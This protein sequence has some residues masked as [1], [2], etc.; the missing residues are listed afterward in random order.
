LE[1]NK[2]KILNA[3][4]FSESEFGEFISNLRLAESQRM[5]ILERILESGEI[6]LQDLENTFNISP[7][8]LNLN[9][10]YLKELDLLKPFAK[11][12]KLY[13]TIEKQNEVK[14]LFPDVSIIRDKHLCCGCGL[15]V[16]VCPVNAIDFLKD[17][18]TINSDS[19]I[20][21]G[22]C[23]ICCPRAF[24]PD[25]LKNL[26]DDSEFDVKFLNE[27]G[28]FE[29]IYTAQTK[30]NKIKEVG[31]DGGVVSTLLIT[32][33]KTQIID[34][35]LVVTS[36]NL[37]KPI[38]ILIENEDDVLKSAGTKYSNA[39]PLSILHSAKKF[40][41]LAIIGTP[42]VLEG[43]QKISFYPLNKPLFNN[44][45]LK[46]GL[47]CM[48]SFD[49]EDII[50]IVNQE[51]KV[52]PDKIKKMNIKKGRFYVYQENG[53]I[54]DIPVEQVKKYARYGCFLCDDLTSELTDVS[55]GSIGSEPNWST[56]IVRSK[57]GADLM[58]KAS[59]LQLIDK[60]LIEETNKNY[61]MLRRIAKSKEK[62][63]KEI[64]R[65]KMVQQKPKIRITNFNEVPCGLTSEMVK[66]ESLRCLQCGRPLC[67]S[68][69]PVNVNIPGFISLLRKE[70]YLEGIRFIKDYNLL[71]AICGRVCPQE[72]QCENSCL[73]NSIGEPVAIGNLERF[74]ADWERSNKL[75]ECPDCEAPNG[76][77]V[78][79][80][81]CG[82]ASLTCAGELARKGY[83]ITIFEAFH[84]GGGVLSYGI[85]EF[86]LPKEIVVDEIQTLTMLNV[87][88]EY[89]IIIGKTLSIEDLKEMGFK[90]I[91]IGVGAGLPTFIDI[92]G[93]DFN[94]VLSANEFLTRSNLMKAYKFPEYDTPIKVG[95]ITTVLGGGNVALDSARTALRLGA[96]RVIVIY[97]RSEKEMPARQEEY[98]HAIEEGVEFLFLTNP[99]RIIG[100][101]MGNVKQIE[102]IKMRLGEPDKSGRK[103]PI[104][105]KGSEYFID[106]DTI[107]VAIG[108][109]ANPILTRA[110]PGLKLNKRGYIET[111]ENG[112][113]NL[114]GIYAGGDIVTGSAT[115]ISAMGAG[116]KAARAMDEYLKSKFISKSSS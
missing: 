19:C 58:E 80:I 8:V 84:A 93:L 62:M 102:V 65:T 30:L 42:C 27:L 37:F 85:P 106:T 43:I 91:F 116:K 31:Q 51:F 49:Y 44:I 87:K 81:G 95:E 29:R 22:L 71:P 57:K 61:N 100:D 6:N 115:V 24:F 78:A 77:K 4:K 83:D 17:S 25:E 112:K 13:Q 7:D 38:P 46:I 114:E 5:R 107:I 90:A 20:K 50:N 69:C 113:T 75:K 45:A 11:I 101:E 48:E 72:S 105:I 67:I 89:N 32:A 74:I 79:I 39:H 18:L 15:C 60:K 12:S 16:A 40:K 34:A 88:I 3:K 73:L 10:E 96:K 52:A 76:I 47:F 14:G 26:M 1:K 92:P 108:T 53:E 33:F 56:V 70:N 98:H 36:D 97:R 68:G 35:A 111:D 66:L 82:P 2:E 55:V 94:G 59:E 104:P 54:L 99:V 21:C 41:K 110:I 64:P 86:R 103:S 109:Q 63:Y 28:Y 23:Y 9:L